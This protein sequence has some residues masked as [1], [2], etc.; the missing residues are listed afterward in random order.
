AGLFATGTATA[1]AIKVTPNA[2]LTSPYRLTLGDNGPSYIFSS[3]NT[4]FN[5]P[6]GVTTQGSALIASLGEPF[7]DP[8]QP[9]GYFPN[10]TFGPDDGLSY[11]GYNSR[12]GHIST[13][14]ADVYIGLK[15]LLDDGY[16]YGYAEVV[17]SDA[18]GANFRPRLL[19]YGYQT[20][21]GTAITTGE[22]SAAAPVPE[23]AS[24]GMALLALLLIG[25][26][27][28]QRSRDLL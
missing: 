6:I 2:D 20:T 13:S 17:G 1:T 28:R 25:G 18:T 11:T 14:T 19:S 21:A 15:F 12:T 22:G 27:A 9:S 23:P 4:L 24:W 3:R 26:L 5:K 10:Q 8:P 7:Y 16:H